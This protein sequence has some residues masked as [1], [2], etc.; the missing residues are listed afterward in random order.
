MPDKLYYLPLRK[1]TEA[2][3]RSTH[4]LPA[5][6]TPLIGRAQEIQVACALLRRAEIRLLTLTGPG[7]VGKTRL[8]LQVATELLEDFADG[9]FFVSLAPISDPALVVPTIVQVLDLKEV[10]EQALPDLLKAFLSDKELLLLL[11][12]FEQVVTAAP[13]LS[14]LL[15]TCPEVK[16]LV[17]SRAVLHLQGEHEFLLPPLAIPDLKQVPDPEALAQYTAV[18]LFLRRAQASQPAF[19]LTKPNARA[20]AEICVRLDGLPLALE[21]AAARIKLLPPQALLKR[22]EH[23][24]SVLTGGPQNVPTRQ[25]TLRNTIQWSYDLLSDQE[26]RLFRRLSVFVGGCTLEAAAAMYNTDTDQAMEIFDGVVSLLDKSLLQQTE[27]EGEEPHLLMLETIREYGLECLRNRGELEAA[28]QAHAAYYLALAEEAEFKLKSIE[29]SVWLERLKR[30]YENLRAVLQWAAASGNEEAHLALRLSGA[31]WVFWM[32]RGYPSEGR[33]FL[34]QALARSEA[35]EAPPRV[36][37]LI[38]VQTM[39]LLQGDYDRA[40][41]MSEEALALSRKLGDQQGIAYALF[42]QGSVA[43]ARHNY[44]Q[45]RTM[46][47]ESLAILRELGEHYGV[48]YWL[49]SLGRAAFLQGDN[50]RAIELLEESLALFRALDNRADLAWALFLL[51]RVVLSKGDTARAHMLIEESLALHREIDNKWGMAY[52]LNLLGQIAFQQGEM[53]M[54]DARLRESIQLYHEL[55]DRRGESRSLLLSANLS[56]VQEDYAMAYTRYEESLTL[57]KSLGHRG[58]IAS[59][60]KG[61]GIVAAAQG[62]PIPAVH[63]W[64]AAEKLGETHGVSVPSAI[65]ERMRAEVRAH[66]GEQMFADAL[67]QGR[68]M[69]PEQ[70]IA[71][72]GPAT[73][74]QLPVTRLPLAPPARRA[75]TKLTKLTA[76]EVEVLRL[77]AQGLTDAQVAEALVI[78]RRTVNWY[79]TTI[80]SKLGVSSRSAATRYAIEHK[81]AE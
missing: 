45:A 42:G 60:L 62:Q 73:V 72:R 80:Y 9:V 37:V 74:P 19:Q 75:P 53:I 36:K 7:G 70:I 68:I 25:Q 28:Q 10:G 17:T 24:F 66:L 38:G 8:G 16:L 22:L 65:Y 23:R 30:E 50:S 44:A 58:L 46:I 40:E 21:L 14:E 32:L 35:I 76:R 33:T 61:L 3:H 69:S 29:Q 11:D 54:A 67:A 71:S 56:A 59:G 4:T 43:L 79:L 77:V 13:R 5:Q 12:N 18:A 81:L 48:A 49:R 27:Q 51:A 2:E 26:Q 1:P 31:L 15:V 64:G 6:L 39:A 52:A 47:Q 63:L 34:E 20:V 57:A 41:Q 78:S 55:G